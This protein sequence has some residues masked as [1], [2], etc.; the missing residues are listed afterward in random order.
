MGDPHFLSFILVPM[1]KLYR[2]IFALLFVVASMSNMIGHGTRS[3][4]AS[5]NRAKVQGRPSMTATVARSKLVDVGV[6]V[7]EHP[8]VNPSDSAEKELFPCESLQITAI[9]AVCDGARLDFPEVRLKDVLEEDRHLPRESNFISISE[10]TVGDAVYRNLVIVLRWE[11]ATPEFLQIYLKEYI[12]YWGDRI[13]YRLFW[14]AQY[15]IC[16][17]RCS[18]FSESGEYLPADIDGLSPA[19]AADIN[20]NGVPAAFW[21][22]NINP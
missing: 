21:N 6:Q 12:P 3:K 2:T 19:L 11:P 8:S 13:P 20:F 16:T 9:G 17:G 7:D 18:T 22:M 5:L 4:I 14:N 15:D 1:D 10:K